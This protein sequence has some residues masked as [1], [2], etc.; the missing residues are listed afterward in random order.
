MIDRRHLLTLTAAAAASAGLPAWAQT[1][2]PAVEVS[3]AAALRGV[4]QAVVA[5]FAIGFVTNRTDR[6][7]AGGGLLGSGFGG[8]ST[9]RSALE[10]LTDA[11]FQAATDAAYDIFV[12]RMGAGGVTLGDRQPLLDAFGT[13]VRPVETEERDL[14]YGRD[15]RGKVRIFG[16]S[17]LGGGAIV[18]REWLGMI[19]GG[20]MSG[21]AS[22]VQ[23]SMGAQNFA[24]A[25]NQAVLGCMLMLDFANAESYGGWH[26]N[27]SAVEVNSSLGAWPELTQLNVFAAGNGRQGTVALEDPIGIGGDF[28]VFADSTT[29]GQRAAETAANVI[30]V[31]G[32]VGTNSTRRYTM[33]ADPTRWR[34]GVS[35][36]AREAIGALAGGLSA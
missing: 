18:M 32:G 26:R 13:R 33:T 14:V 10:G 23:A 5:S 25:N 11:D 1:A 15:D 7:R 16:P 27:M 29:G 2:A 31:L 36:V 4:S 17:Q 19:T 3:N 24:R 34:A 20:G 30:G 28:G 8:R 6:A 35:E 9:A 22:A 12:E 21:N